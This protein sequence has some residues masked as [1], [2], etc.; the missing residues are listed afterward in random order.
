MAER[1]GHDMRQPAR[2]VSLLRLLL[3]AIALA[4]VV[5]SLQGRKPELVAPALA[6]LRLLLITVAIASAFL[7]A[8]VAWVRWRWQLA[9]HLVF[10]L[11]WTGLLVHLSGGV[12]SPAVAVLFAIILIGTLVLPG[13]APFVLPALASLTL[14][15][16]A[17][18]YIAGHTP[19]PPEYFI[20]NPALADSNRILGT[21]ATQV[22]ALFLVDLLG[23]ALSRRL[24]EER[25][26]ANEVIDQLGEGVI[27]ADRH[28]A[29]A[30]LNAEAI[31]LLELGATI[32]PGSSVATALMRG[33]LATVR[34]LLDRP[35]AT[36]L[37]RWTGPRGRQLVL[38]LDELIGRHGKPI[39]RVLL[40]ADETRLRELE[41]SARRSEHL[42]ALGEMAAGIAHEVRNPLTSLRGCAQELSEIHRKSGDR[43]ASDLAGILVAE[44]DRL[45]RIVEDFLALS[46]MRQPRREQLALGPMFDELRQQL[47]RSPEMPASL[48]FVI[49][50][51]DG[52]PPV[53]A[54]PD[55]VRQILFNLVTNA[56]DAVRSLAEPQLEVRARS[57]EE[58][59]PLAV[60]AV[61]LSVRDNGSGIAPE[62]QERI[63]TPFYST[64]SRGTGLGLSLVQRLVR[65]H[66]GVLTLDSAPNKGTTLR[67]YLPIASATREFTRALGGS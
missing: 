6:W 35:H 1:T 47:T 30:Y 61:E 56:C 66:E 57:A 50:V 17:L 10:D 12:G 16:S 29:I 46:R 55:Q 62:I 7:V 20:A 37:E 23:Q 19:F 11:L 41:D 5:F 42:A 64:K 54:D 67:I 45:A 27:A 8:T 59:N 40:I 2:Q 18:L 38:R 24:R 52:T 49:E 33:D 39:G 51:E 21:L 25:I 65:E 48:R 60:P 34:A 9:L 28:G 44:S 43:D 58:D 3:L 63:F 53:L 15:G 36:T 22:A 32:A 26:F 14:A 31:R 4:V 13:V